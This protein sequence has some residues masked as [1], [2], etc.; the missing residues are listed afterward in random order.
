[1]FPGSQP[2]LIAVSGVRL[3]N[4]RGDRAAGSRSADLDRVTPHHLVGPKPANHGVSAIVRV[5]DDTPL[6]ILEVS[7][8]PRTGQGKSDRYSIPGRRPAVPTGGAAAGT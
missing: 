3:R 4:A 2:I 8:W 7:A 6:A 1:L 5:Y